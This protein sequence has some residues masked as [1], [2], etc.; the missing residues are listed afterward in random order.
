MKKMISKALNKLSDILKTIK[1]D[2]QAMAWR[3]SNANF[4]GYCKSILDMIAK[5]SPEAESQIVDIFKNPPTTKQVKEKLATLA[6]LME[7]ENGE[8]LPKATADFITQYTYTASNTLDRFGNRQQ[9]PAAIAVERRAALSILW[10][11]LCS[12]ELPRRVNGL[13]DSFIPANVI[14]PTFTPAIDE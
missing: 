13:L 4:D 8:T 2:G 5:E 11:H 1:D 6:N 9:Y 12:G 3:V 14:L 7:E 10:Y